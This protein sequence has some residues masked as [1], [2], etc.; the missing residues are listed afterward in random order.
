MAKIWANSGDSHFLEPDDLWRSRL[1]KQLAGLCPRAEKDPDGEY[2][3]VFVDGQVFRRK[4]PS[5]ALVDFAQMSMRAQGNRD[6]R[7]RLADLDQEGIW[8]EVIFPSL[9]MWASS[10]RTPELLKACMRASNEWALEEIVAVSPRYVVTAQVSTLVVDDAVEEMLWA[11]DKGFKA[12]FLPTTPHPS[13]PDWHRDDWEPL[14]AA[15]EEAGMVLAFHIGTDPVEVTAANSVTGGAGLVYRGPGG[16]IMNYAET[17]FSGQR[18][19]MKLVA[20]GA[21][22]RHP[23][24]KVLISEGGATW[25]PFLG[26]RLLEGYRQHHMV[27][28]PKLS[29]SP[30]EILFNQVYASFQHDE[31]AVQAF[32]HMGYRN[33]MFGSDYPHMEGTF[34]HTQDT[35]KTL[36]DG[37]SDETRLRITQGAF[38]ELF[39]DVPPVAAES[40]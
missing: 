6:A 31:T 29:R 37:V 15:A 26:D 40:V 14:W 13:A 35:L 38:F 23:N 28:R 32:E 39:P 5:S 19:T 10:F 25:V 33:V 27:V 1:P 3:T 8:G 2:E 24:L 22:D 30:K 9:G 11:A 7:A 36:F 16:A 21:L 17:T 12:I 34:G 20:S 18:A 4:L